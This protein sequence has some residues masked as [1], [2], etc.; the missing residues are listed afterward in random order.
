MNGDFVAAFRDA[1]HGVFETMLGIDLVGGLASETEELEAK[2]EVSGIIGMSGNAAGDVVA[3]FDRSLAIEAT[4]ALIGSE[5]NGVDE[6]VVDAIGELTNMIAGSAKGKLAQYEMTLALP[7]VVYGADG[8]HVGFNSS[9]TPVA[10]AFKTD[11]GNLTVQYALC[12]KHEP[13]PV[14]A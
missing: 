13:V 5:P 14:S 7:T 1:T 3:S 11:H 12:E 2:H 4:K 8:Y 6:D 10:L 9:I